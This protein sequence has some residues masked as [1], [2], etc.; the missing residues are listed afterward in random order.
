MKALS[1]S[2]PITMGLVISLIGAV[3]AITTISNRTEANSNDIKDMKTKVDS[4]GQMVTDV[5]VIRAKVE[6]IEKRVK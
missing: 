1:E 5:A 2:T 3:I 6:T 4:L